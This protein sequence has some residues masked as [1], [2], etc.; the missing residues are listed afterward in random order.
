MRQNLKKYFW[1]GL[2]VAVMAWFGISRHHVEEERA[3]R[4]AGLE[5][6]RSVSV[7]PAGVEETWLRYIDKRFSEEIQREGQNL[8]VRVSY[9]EAEPSYAYVSL[10]H[11]YKIDCNENDLGFSISFGE[12][13]D[14]VGVILTGVISSDFK[15]EPERFVAPDSVASRN[16]DARL[17]GYIA[18]Q[19]GALIRQPAQP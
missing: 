10:N 5:A 2:C 11:S 12:G 13:E 18:N 6:A 15:N 3:L 19:L 7:L 17:C 4:V 16:L 9:I 14:S 1:L 8:K